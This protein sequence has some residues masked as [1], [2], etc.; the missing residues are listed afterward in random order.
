MER[1]TLEDQITVSKMTDEECIEALVPR[2]GRLGVDFRIF[3]HW[4]FLWHLIHWNWFDPMK[5]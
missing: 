1:P 2:K 3:C 4:E 5:D